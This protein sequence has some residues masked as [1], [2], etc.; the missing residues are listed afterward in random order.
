MQQYQHMLIY[1]KNLFFI[2][3]KEIRLPAGQTQ[4][5]AKIAK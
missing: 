3:E 2:I 4:K 5:T 1:K